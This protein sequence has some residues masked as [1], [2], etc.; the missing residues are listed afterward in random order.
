MK[1]NKGGTGK[2]EKIT[3][4]EFMK[5]WHESEDWGDQVNHIKDLHNLEKDTEEGLNLIGIHY[6]EADEV[7]VVDDNFRLNVWALQLAFEIND[8]IQGY[9]VKN[10]KGQ[11]NELDRVLDVVNKKEEKKYINNR[12]YYYL[13][14]FVNPL[15]DDDS[16]FDYGNSWVFT[17]ADIVLAVLD[18]N[19]KGGDE[20]K[21]FEVKKETWELMVK[22][23]QEV[24][25]DDTDGGEDLIPMPI[26]QEDHEKCYVL[27]NYDGGGISVHLWTYGDIYFISQGTPSY[28]HQQLTAYKGYLEKGWLWDNHRLEILQ[29]LQR[30]DYEIDE[31]L[32]AINQ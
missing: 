21:A 26:P 29:N 1:N 13:L 5:K 20:I 18:D 23:I 22:T 31:A 27:W 16:Y 8:V 7:L 6:N 17:I 3:N 2:M 19:D 9:T 32:D 10:D 24:T 15:P 12:A 30:L 28:I 11:W 14:N 4:K 25:S